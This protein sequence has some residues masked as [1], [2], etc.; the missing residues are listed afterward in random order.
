MNLGHISFHLCPLCQNCYTIEFFFIYVV[1]CDRPYT[2][3]TL[4]FT[5]YN[6]DNKYPFIVIVIVILMFRYLQEIYHKLWAASP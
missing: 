6:F 4:G 2:R 1:S 3:I 5:L